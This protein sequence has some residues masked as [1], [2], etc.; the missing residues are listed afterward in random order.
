MKKKKAI[1]SIILIILLLSAGLFFLIKP[2]IDNKIN[3]E[4]QEDLIEAIEQGEETID[5]EL[6]EDN[7]SPDYYS[8]DFNNELKTMITPVP[9]EEPVDNDMVTQVNGIGIIKIEVIDL[10]LP[11]VEGVENSK[12]KVA[13]GHL[14]SSAKIGEEGNCIIAGHR[15]Y[16]YGEMFN[17]LDE[18]SVGDIIRIITIEGIAYE[19]KVY[20]ITMVEPG[21]ESLF[22]CDEDQCKLTLITCTPVR[23]ATHRLL[24][25]AELME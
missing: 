3:L 10:K 5:I 7:G 15:N 22:E 19:Y 2:E 14:T 24:V 18:V 16:T 11:I 20:K 6:Y 9:S 12:L 13:V 21:S 17:R 23:K 4:K 25:M 1:A 8:I